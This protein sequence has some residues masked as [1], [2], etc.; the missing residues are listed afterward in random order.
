MDL[1]YRTVQVL[2]R[3]TVRVYTL[4]VVEIDLKWIFM[5]IKVHILKAVA[6]KVL[7]N[8]LF[9]TRAIP[10]DLNKIYIIFLNIL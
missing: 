10:I 6:V 5:L 2:V 9:F 7:Y 3:V 1:I 8:V 4:K